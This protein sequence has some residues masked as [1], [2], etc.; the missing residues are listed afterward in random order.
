MSI[1]EI[2]FQ[3]QAVESALEQAIEG[4]SQWQLT[5][6]RL[7]HDKVAI[8]SIVVILVMVVLALLAPVFVSILAPRGISAYPMLACRRRASRWV[9]APMASRSAPTTS[10]A[11]FWSGSSTAR[12]SPCSSGSSPP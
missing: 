8:A 11:T 6:R 4:R 2:E 3:A 1:T 12:A 5:W 10:A 9:L 7:R